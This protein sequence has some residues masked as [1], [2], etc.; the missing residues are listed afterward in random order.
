MSEQ[1]VQYQIGQV[2]NGYRW[3]GTA[4][5]PAGAPTAQVPGQPGGQPVGGPP[6]KAWYKQW[7]GIGILAFGALVLIGAI[8]GGGGDTTAT[9]EP[10]SQPT[11]QATQPAAEEATDVEAAAEAPAEEAAA[12]IGDP[13][14]D[15]KFEFTVTG[16]ES[17]VDEVGDEFLSETAQ[18][19]YTL[20]TVKI[21]NIG[22]EAQTFFS[23]NVT[24]IDSKDRKLASDSNAT[25]YA[26]SDNSGWIEEINPGNSIE[27]VIAFDV[28]KGA[29]LVAV[30]LHDSAFSGGVV[31]TLK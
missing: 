26:N 2:V 11:E 22:D 16:V 13:V 31:V 17:G 28:A 12:G 19:A 18:G 5:E 15:G 14:R 8:F 25:L 24:G 9:E 27:A 30:E 29:K 7:W 10:A 4:W 3:S 23:D 20:V 1:P 21:E 6:K